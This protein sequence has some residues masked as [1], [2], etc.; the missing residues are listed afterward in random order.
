MTGGR[1]SAKSPPPPDPL[2]VPAPEYPG[3]GKSKKTKKKL[4]Y[5]GTILASG[6]NQ[7]NDSILNTGS[8][9]LG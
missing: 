6:L 5:Y 9:K 4:G 8:D 3:E 1:G 2:P 7:R